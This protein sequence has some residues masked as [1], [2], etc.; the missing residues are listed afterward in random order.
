MPLEFTL[1]DDLGA[2]ADVLQKAARGRI[3]L[4]E[5]LKAFGEGR[6]VSDTEADRAFVDEQLQPLGTFGNRG[7]FELPQR[8][9]FT[10]LEDPLSES[11]RAVR[12]NLLVASGAAL[13]V[14]VSGAV[15][16]TIP[17]FDMP[18]EG[19]VLVVLG[20][21]AMVT[22]WELVSFW[23]YWDN[24]VLRLRIADEGVRDVRSQLASLV[25]RIE[26]NRPVIEKASEGPRLVAGAKVRAVL[27]VTRER[28]RRFDSQ[29][30][31]VRVRRFLEGPAVFLVGLVALASLAVRAYPLIR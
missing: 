3:P 28:M 21:L 8:E 17:G 16:K 11:T 30:R 20:A 14:T 31:S 18:I 22:A 26:E 9:L 4:H 7:L 13:F 10:L 15:P 1:L 25:K 2:L 27:E 24:D 6:D 19:S 29:R 23:S 5:S 12:R